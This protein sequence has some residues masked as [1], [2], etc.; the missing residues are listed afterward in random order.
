MV[1]SYYIFVVFG[2]LKSCSCNSLII[3]LVIIPYSLEIVCACSV[4]VLCITVSV[5]GIIAK[6]LRL[7]NL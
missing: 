3:L 1:F 4:C 5:Y 2:R 6:Y 7:G